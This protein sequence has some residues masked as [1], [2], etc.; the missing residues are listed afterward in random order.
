MRPRIH[1]P[2]LLVAILFIASC[3]DNARSVMAQPTTFNT[4]PSVSLSGTAAMAFAQPVNNFLC[5][6]ISPFNVPIVVVVQPT[7]VVTVVVTE[8][9]LQ[10]VDTFGSRLPQVTLPAP[11]PT[12]QFGT[13]LADARAAQSF[14]LTMGIGCGTGHTGSLSIFV[15]TRDPLGHRGSSQTT[16]M[17]H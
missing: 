13:A 11:L 4:V 8:I 6:S 15:D 1:G 17:V 12:A 7:G 16:V 2:M 14:P 10:F 9:R 5:P 3:D